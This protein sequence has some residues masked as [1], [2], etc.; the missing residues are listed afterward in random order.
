M[1]FWR[2]SATVS[3]KDKILNHVIRGKW[4]LEYFI[5]ETINMV[6]TR[7]MN[8]SRWSKQVLQGITPGRSMIGRP[9]VR[10]MKGIYNA[11]EDKG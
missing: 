7:S 10:W 3:R 1:F 11:M 4:V 6:W 9:R 8:G 2:Q 5:L